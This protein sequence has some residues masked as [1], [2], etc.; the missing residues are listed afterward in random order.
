MEG[1]NGILIDYAWCTGCFSCQV[2][3]Q[4]EHGYPLDQ[5]GIKVIEIGPWEYEPDKWQLA[6]YA[7]PTDQCDLCADRVALG[8]GPS[9]VQ[10]CQ[11]KC[12]EFGPVEELAAK[13]TDHPKQVL[14]A[15]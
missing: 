11:A 6:Y 1:K 14:F 5:F 7:L 13:L 2:A 4:M 8:K 10:H 15:L 3:C 12:M 9:C